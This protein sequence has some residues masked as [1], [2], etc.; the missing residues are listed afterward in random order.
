MGDDVRST[1]LVMMM[2]IGDDIYHRSWGA[3]VAGLLCARS[4]YTP[5][6]DLISTND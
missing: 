4:V 3:R 1:S 2:T 5:G 6:S